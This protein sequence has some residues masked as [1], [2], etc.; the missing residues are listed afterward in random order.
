MFFHFAVKCVFIDMSRPWNRGIS[1]NVFMAL[2][3]FFATASNVVGTTR[4]PA[5]GVFVI[6]KQAEVSFI[7]KLHKKAL[8]SQTLKYSF[9]IFILWPSIN[10]SRILIFLVAFCFK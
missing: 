1:E 8:Y 7:I 5:L 9:I 2:M 4:I 6:G 3:K 10:K